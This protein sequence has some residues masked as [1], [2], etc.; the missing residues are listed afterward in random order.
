[1][2]IFLAVF[3]AA[4]AQD[5]AGRL[6]ERLRG[7]G[8]GVS[9]VRRDNLHYTLR[10]MGELGESGLS[11]VGEA[12]REGAA[13]HR[14]IDAVL[15]AAGAFPNARKA[16]VLWLGL[17]Q[18]GEAFTELARAVERSLRGRGF[19]PADH[20]FRPHL[21]IGRVRERDADWS[22]RLAGLAAE[23][24]P[25]ALDRIAIVQ[26]TLSPKGSIYE[27]RAEVPLAEGGG[28]NG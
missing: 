16:R 19:D 9:W 12:A 6:I 28:S 8:D 23:P 5:A 4:E 1:V 17:A 15:G 25:F 10:F 3:P 18:G 14:R 20:P 11:R 22:D 13:G 26:S 2:R 21:T 24:V 7:E 27:V